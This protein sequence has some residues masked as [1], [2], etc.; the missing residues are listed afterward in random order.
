M[1]AF[2]NT[3]STIGALCAIA[4]TC[5]ASPAHASSGPPTLALKLDGRVYAP[6]TDVEYVPSSDILILFGDSIGPC[7]QEG[8]P[9]GH[10]QATISAV[11]DGST[12]RLRGGANAP[13]M[14]ITPDGVITLESRDGN[15]ICNEPLDLRATMTAPTD[16]TYGHSSIATIT[17]SNHSTSM[18]SGV[19]IQISSDSGIAIQ[20]ASG[21][22]CSQKG[23]GDLECSLGSMSP[24]TQIVGEIEIMATAEGEWHIFCSLNGG[25][26]P[27]DQACSRS[28]NVELPDGIFTDRFR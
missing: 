1:P 2:K 25:V 5:L 19:M 24:S 20:E 23:A 28:I 13:P 6:I 18:I 3:H 17:I 16:L 4:I 26:N 22:T 21:V 7:S 8:A 11:I 10:T 27:S 15:V 9:A 12:V 14:R